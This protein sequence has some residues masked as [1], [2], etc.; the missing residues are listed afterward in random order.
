MMIGYKIYKCILQIGCGNFEG[1]R[2]I[3]ENEISGYFNESI[4]RF[5]IQFFLLSNFSYLPTILES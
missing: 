1:K 4:L 3:K 5:G 2:G